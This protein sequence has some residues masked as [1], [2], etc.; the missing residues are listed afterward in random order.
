[1]WNRLCEK[2]ADRIDFL[3]IYIKEA[4]ASDEWAL[5][6]YN[7]DVCYRQPRNLPQRLAIAK[8]L[9]KNMEPSCPLV[10]DTM[11]NEASLHYVAWPERLFVIK[12]GV[13]VFQGEHADELSL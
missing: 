7:K 3:I 6:R 13:V 9:I 10:V 4:H 5:E 8:D 12:D 11:A 1:M 2:Y